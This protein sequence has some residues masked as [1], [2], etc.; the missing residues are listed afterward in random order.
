MVWHWGLRFEGL[1]NRAATYTRE[2]K[3]EAYTVPSPCG[4]FSALHEHLKGKQ[5]TRGSP[6][7]SSQVPSTDGLSEQAGVQCTRWMAGW[8]L[9][10][11]GGSL[12]SLPVLTLSML[13]IVAVQGPETESLLLYSQV[14][15]SDS[16]LHFFTLSEIKYYKCISKKL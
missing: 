1:F 14:C 9:S 13:W 2:G 5:R 11:A 16:R 6:G 3:S 12:W 4:R 8:M 7:E 15:L 10:A